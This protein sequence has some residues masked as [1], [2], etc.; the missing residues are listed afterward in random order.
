VGL[1]SV[2]VPDINTEGKPTNDPD[3]AVAWKR[4]TNPP[5]VEERLLKRNQKHFG[6]AN[7]TLFASKPIQEML[8][9]EGV[10]QGV[11]LLLEG[12]FKEHILQGT[13]GSARC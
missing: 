8:T 4:I 7:N 2:E 6:Q 9:Y 3:K 10:N 12:K 1:A 13:Q 11:N 5:E